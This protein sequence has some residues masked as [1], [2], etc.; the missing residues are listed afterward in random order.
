VSKAYISLAFYERDPVDLAIEWGQGEQPPIP[1]I[2]P[3]HDKRPG[4]DWEAGMNSPLAPI[5]S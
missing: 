1:V 3:A 5:Y 4:G 2:M